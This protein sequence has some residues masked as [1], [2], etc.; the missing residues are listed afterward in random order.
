[1]PEPPEQECMVMPFDPAGPVIPALVLPKQTMTPEIF[2][3][4]VASICP[5]W[6]H[7]RPPYVNFAHG[8]YR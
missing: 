6:P 7:M 2:A 8:G 5:H 4:S 3:R 1:M